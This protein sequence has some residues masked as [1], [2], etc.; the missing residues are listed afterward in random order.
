ML[1]LRR[2]LLRTLSLAC[3][4]NFILT[5]DQL[6]TVNGTAAQPV[7]PPSAGTAVRDGIAPTTEMEKVTGIGGFFIRAQDAT[8]W[9]VGTSNT[10]GSRLH[11]RATRN[12]F[13]SRK[14]DPPFSI[15]NRRRVAFSEMST[16]C[17]C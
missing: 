8:R 1:F 5:G 7:I 15:L 14:Q 11:H 17:A 3:G 10:R 6:G 13:G 12:P 16:K 2:Q 9:G 4:S